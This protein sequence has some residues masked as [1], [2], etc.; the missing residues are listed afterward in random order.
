[1]ATTHASDAS[2]E[3]LA[4]ECTPLRGGGSSAK[5]LPSEEGRP[6]EHDRSK[7]EVSKRMMIGLSIYWWGFAVFWFVM[8]IVVLPSQIRKLVSDERKGE[9][10][11]MICLFASF[12]SVLGAP[13][14]GTVSDR[15]T[16][17]WGRRRPF[18]VVGT[19]GVVAM[20][21][22]MGL[23]ENVVFF[24]AFYIAMQT[25]SNLA[26]CPFNALVPDVIPYEQRGTASGYLGA[27]YSLGTLSGTVV[28]Y[29]YDE[30]G[31][32]WTSALLATIMLT[33][34]AVTFS[35][36]EEVPLVKAQEDDIDCGKL[37]REF[38]TPFKNQDLGGS[39]SPACSCSKA[40]SQCR[41][42]CSITSR[43]LSTYPQECQWRAR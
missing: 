19:L 42:S 32:G 31:I 26:A 39:S 28:G 11:G 6:A 36:V 38:F 25:F 29:Y 24:G 10:L 18:L 13:L 22:G 15:C 8:L 27:A 17:R 40:Y 34:V 2:E 12:F 35:Q 5:V 30:L 3:N 23:S 33:S 16:H 43:T 4:D 21:A 1:M 37:C 9:T 20:L 41:S 14:F 7:H